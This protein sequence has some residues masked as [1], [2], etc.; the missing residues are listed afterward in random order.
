MNLSDEDP[1]TTAT[2]A[3]EAT[4]QWKMLAS[5]AVDYV[6]ERSRCMLPTMSDVVAEAETRTFFF[7]ES[8]LVSYHFLYRHVYRSAN[9]CT[10]DFLLFVVK[11]Q[12]GR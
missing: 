6:T 11:R 3:T 1:I 9:P 8:Q 10:S 4:V 5:D 7:F 12:P 2:Y